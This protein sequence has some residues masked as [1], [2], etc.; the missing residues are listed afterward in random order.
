M[1]TGRNRGS[2]VRDTD[3]TSVCL[4][5]LAAEEVHLFKSRRQQPLSGRARVPLLGRFT[6]VDL[7]IRAALAGARGAVHNQPFLV[8]Y[9]RAGQATIRSYDLAV[10]DSE[11]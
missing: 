8:Y 6:F 4:I 5:A 7:A 10:L 2:T 1:R 9:G 3:E 11:I